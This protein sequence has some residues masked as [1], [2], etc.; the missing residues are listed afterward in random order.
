ML[1]IEVAK[2][3]QSEGS[4]AVVGLVMIDSV[5]PW[6]EFAGNFDDGTWPSYHAAT[7]TTVQAKVDTSF[8]NVRELCRAWVCPSHFRLPPAVLIC[9]EDRAT[10]GEHGTLGW[11][12]FDCL[13]F[14]SVM[15]TPGDHFTMFADEHVSTK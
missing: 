14:I 8:D 7:S 1:S 3:L 5:C 9:A 12:G 6:S 13:N 2:L 4:P 11:A 15:L 10:R